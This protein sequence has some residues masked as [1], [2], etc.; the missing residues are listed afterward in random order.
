VL[1]NRNPQLLEEVSQ[2]QWSSA[3]YST[4]SCSGKLRGTSSF[5]DM[6]CTLWLLTMLRFLCAAWW[7]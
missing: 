5:Q 3:G 2:R 7:A 6:C 4:K 1:V